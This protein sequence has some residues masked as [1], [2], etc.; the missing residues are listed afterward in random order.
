MKLPWRRPQ[1]ASEPEQA[2]PLQ[3]WCIE[4][5]DITGRWAPITGIDIRVALP[6]NILLHQWEDR[7]GLS[8]EEIIAVLKVCVE[9]QVWEEARSKYKGRQIRIHNLV[10]GDFMPF[11]ILGIERPKRTI[12]TAAQEATTKKKD[13]IDALKSQMQNRIDEAMKNGPPITAMPSGER[14]MIEELEQYQ[15]E[16]KMSEIGR[17][18]Y[19]G[20]GWDPA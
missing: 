18:R 5:M 3:G 7:K 17:H 13:M 4:A 6:D 11:E 15:S 20:T 19:A 16:E 9:H 10:T 2:D 14:A 1:P 8:F 12:R